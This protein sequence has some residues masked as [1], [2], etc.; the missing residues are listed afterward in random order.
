VAGLP[1]C[2]CKVIDIAGIAGIAGFQ[3]INQSINKSI[4]Q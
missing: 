2:T 4:N 1:V 3:Q